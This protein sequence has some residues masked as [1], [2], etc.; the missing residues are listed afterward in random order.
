MR[1]KC[2]KALTLDTCDDD[3]FYVDGYMEI[4]VGEV[5]EVGNEKII[6]GEIHLDG[7][8]VNKWIEISKEMLEK[9]FVEVEG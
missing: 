5:Y 1:Y 9:H 6:D 8:N 2:V 7:V 3:G 4:E